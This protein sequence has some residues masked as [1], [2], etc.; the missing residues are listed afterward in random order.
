MPARFCFRSFGP[1]AA[2]L[3]VLA[4][5]VTLALPAHAAPRGEGH[6]PAPLSVNAL[7]QWVI[8][9]ISV[10]HAGPTAQTSAQT[11]GP[12]DPD[13]SFPLSNCAVDPNGSSCPELD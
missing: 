1:L 11:S 3:A 6:L 7:V 4:L 9:E 8:H 2:T 12:Q 5:L 10:L 13:E